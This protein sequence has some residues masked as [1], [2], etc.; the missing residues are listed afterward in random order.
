MTTKVFKDIRDRSLENNGQGLIATE[1]LGYRTFR[2]VNNQFII[3]SKTVII[4][5]FVDYITHQ[6]MFV[7]MQEL[8]VKT[9]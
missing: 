8:L 7:I 9:N 6:K 2:L 3:T 5:R 1:N 4:W